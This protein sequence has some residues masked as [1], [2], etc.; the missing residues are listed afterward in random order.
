MTR[1]TLLGFFL[2]LVLA[3]FCYRP[4]LSG[5]FL[6][7]DIPNLGGLAQIDDV[8]TAS[9]FVL[10]GASGPTG[11]PLALL[12]FA[13]QA[14]Q[15]ERGPRAF[16]KVNVF[17]HLL[18]AVLLAWCLYQ[19]ASVMAVE[20]GRAIL[21]ATSA[22]SLWLLLPLLAT[23]S[24]LIVQRMTTLSALFSLLGLGSYLAFR[25]NIEQ[26]PHNS[27]IA[28]TALLAVSTLLATF[29]KESGSLLP[30]FVL[31]IEAT[32][33]MRPESITQRNW[34]IWKFVVLVLPSVAVFAYLASRASYPEW[35]QDRKDFNAWERVLTEAQILWVYIQ[36]AVIGLPVRLG[37][38]QTEYPVSRSLL[39]FKTLIAGSAWLALLFAAIVRRR[40]WPLFALAVFWYLAG[41]VIESTVLPLELYF[42]HRNYLPIIGPVFAL[43]AY[44]LLRSGR[45]WRVGLAAISL[46]VIVNAYLLYVFASIWGEPSFASR[47]WALNYP[48]SS[49]AV[50]NMAKYQ[51]TEEGPQRA[52]QTIRQFTAA[53]PEYAYLGIQ[54]LNISCLF[55]MESDR[56][57]IVAELERDL[58]N[59]A[60]TFTAGRMLSQLFTTTSAIDCGKI[61]PATVERLAVRLHDNAR[62]INDPYYSQFHHKLLAGIARFQGDREATMSNLEKAISYSPSSELNMMMVTALAGAGDFSGADNFINN[63]TLNKPM[64]PLMAFVWQR[65]LEGLRAYVRELEKYVL[66]DQADGTTQG[67]ETDKE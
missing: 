19:L 60:F 47:Y 7:D 18:N 23:S 45:A 4:A 22:A 3:W 29:T 50:T 57:Q 10:S 39:E 34:R 35:M 58:P 67:M 26:T 8:R 48:D 21:V 54:E 41:Q 62:Y 53:H 55:V 44:L 61:T 16:L 52:I 43:C 27:L 28:M 12:T 31:V 38:F 42:E 64:N 25:R 5:A 63:A 37:I 33:L 36:N 56:E 1:L 30:M 49:R 46:L 51:L 15:F 65:D 6:L 11:R 9:D 24:L 32:V 59:V 66:Q 13:L 2:V 20:R 17:I 40:R 14:N